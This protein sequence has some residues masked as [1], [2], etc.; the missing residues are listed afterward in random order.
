MNK[1]EPGLTRRPPKFDNHP[2]GNEEEYE[3]KMCG[4]SFRFVTISACDYYRKK[5]SHAF[6]FVKGCT[7]RFLI[8]LVISVSHGI[9]AWKV[10]KSYLFM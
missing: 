4:V 7:R 2:V 6:V 8:Q 9:P 1:S 5:A 3:R 10:E